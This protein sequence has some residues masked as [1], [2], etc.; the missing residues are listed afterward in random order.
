[1]TPTL[2]D[3]IPAHNGT[4]TSAAA[5]RA[6]VPHLGRLQLDVCSFIRERGSDGATRD[7]IAL[8]LNLK[9]Q[10]ICP[11]VAELIGRRLIRESANTRKTSTGRVA[12]V[13]VYNKPEDDK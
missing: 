12:R 6:I 10:S 8:G 11:R 5:A 7:E 13:L 9:I 1:M 4:A 3:A 2:F